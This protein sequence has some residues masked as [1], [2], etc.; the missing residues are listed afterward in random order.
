MDKPVHQNEHQD[1][2]QH[3]HHHDHSGHVHGDVP[4]VPDK[5]FTDPVCGMK[6]AGDPQKELQQGGQGYHFCSTDCMDKFRANPEAYLAPAP[7]TAEA[8][9]AGAIYTCPMHPQIRQPAPGTCP[10]CGM[11]LEPVMPSLD[12]EENPELAD[13]RRRFWWTLPFTVVV[14]ILAMFGH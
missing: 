1:H 11:T 7:V 8:A 12:D 14:T 10:I 6:V 13:F 4:V 9:P 3:E 5:P 2:G